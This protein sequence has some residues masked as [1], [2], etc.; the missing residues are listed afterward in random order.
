[1]SVDCSH[2]KT[3]TAEYLIYICDSI[4]S[5]I[6]KK[7]IVLSQSGMSLFYNQQIE[8]KTSKGTKWHPL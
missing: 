2:T 5:H 6:E 3:W 8:E 7:D 4:D 1:M